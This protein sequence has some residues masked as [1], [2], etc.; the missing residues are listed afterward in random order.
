MKAFFLFPFLFL[1]LLTFSCDQEDG[2]SPTT[3]AFLDG[4][5]NPLR[6][7]QLSHN[8]E[9]EIEFFVEVVNVASWVNLEDALSLS[10]DGGADTVMPWEFISNRSGTHRGN[11]VNRSLKITLP[12][13]TDE[14]F[15]GVT[16]A[17]V[18]VQLQDRNSGLHFSRELM[19]RLNR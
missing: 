11:Q 5:R 2:S 6:E 1:A 9:G 4:N 12:V 17:F 15:S 14:R 3:V 10:F 8:G 16:T 18:T 7:A 19:I 13:G